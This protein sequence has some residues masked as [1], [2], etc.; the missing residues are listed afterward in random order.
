M[1][2]V[3]H[4]AARREKIYP[5]TYVDGLCRLRKIVAPGASQCDCGAIW[6]VGHEVPERPA[7]LRDCGRPRCG[8]P[9]RLSKLA[10]SVTPSALARHEGLLLNRTGLRP[11]PE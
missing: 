7:R 11:R 2:A 3:L 9:P 10:G 8:A 5:D 1:P 4:P 6:E